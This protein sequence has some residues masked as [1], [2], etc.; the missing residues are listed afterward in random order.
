MKSDV[1][2]VEEVYKCFA[3]AKL[4]VATYDIRW[5]MDMHPI[6]LN[7]LDGGRYFAGLSKNSSGEKRSSFLEDIS[8]ICRTESLDTLLIHMKSS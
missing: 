7:C 4:N 8:T 6:G 1:M 3:F 2:I 5:Y